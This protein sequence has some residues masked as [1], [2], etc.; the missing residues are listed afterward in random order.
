MTRIQIRILFIKSTFN[1]YDE[2]YCVY[3][4]I[5]P[6][7]YPRPLKV[8]QRGADLRHDGLILREIGESRDQKSEDGRSQMTWDEES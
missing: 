6:N 4:H 2:Q 3:R 1:K 8:L 5:E 7:D